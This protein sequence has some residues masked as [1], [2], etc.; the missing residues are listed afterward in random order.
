LEID[1]NYW[2]AHSNLALA[3]AGKGMYNEAIVEVQKAIELS[4]RN[5]MLI[6]MLGYIYAL[7]ERKDEARKVLDDLLELSK[8]EHVSSFCVATVYTCLGQKD[9]AFEWLG[10]AYEEH[11]VY[12]SQLKVF[13][14]LDSLRSDPRYKAL[15]KKMNLE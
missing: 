3:Y 9:Q 14:F 10:K 13:P 12:L 1:Q 5:T 8:K 4:G 11:G 15:L 7:A 6:A 2:V